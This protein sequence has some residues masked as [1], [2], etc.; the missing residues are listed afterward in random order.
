M[1]GND[2]LS[3]NQEVRREF[4]IAL[5]QSMRAMRVTELSYLLTTVSAKC[6]SLHALY[7]GRTVFSS[8]K[9]SRMR[10]VKTA[11]CPDCQLCSIPSRFG[12]RVHAFRAGLMIY[13]V[14]S[15]PLLRILTSIAAMVKRTVYVLWHSALNPRCLLIR[16][17]QVDGL[18]AC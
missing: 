16:A 6:G 1:E 10:R 5:A 2:F 12:W 13:R 3:R 17:C 18:C 8:A 9:S 15:L 14:E 11:P 4:F 7:H